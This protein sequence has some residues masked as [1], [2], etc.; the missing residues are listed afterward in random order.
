MKLFDNGCYMWDGL[1]LGMARGLVSEAKRILQEEDIHD[2]DDIM[3]DIDET[4][5]DSLTVDFFIHI[6]REYCNAGL[7]HNTDEEGKEEEGF[8]LFNDLYFGTQ[9]HLLQSDDTVIDFY[10]KYQAKFGNS[11]PSI[12]ESIHEDIR[13]FFE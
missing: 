11:T 5:I 7:L 4:C 1:V 10:D 3:N 12:G 2:Y 9:H 6:A 8:D 13:V